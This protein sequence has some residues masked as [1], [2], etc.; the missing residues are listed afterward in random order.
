MSSFI[1]DMSRMWK[2]RTLGK[3]MLSKKKKSMHQVMETSNTPM[4]QPHYYSESGEPIYIAAA[5][6]LQAKNTS[7]K[8]LLI[9]LPIGTTWNSLD[10]TVTLKVDTGHM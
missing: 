5:H 2:E 3:H 1:F 6:M 10:K 8:K 7:K 4:G 9:E